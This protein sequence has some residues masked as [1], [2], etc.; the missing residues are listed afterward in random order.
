MKMVN[1]TDDDREWFEKA[2][3]E[4]DAGNVLSDELQEVPSPF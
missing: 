1:I 4:A 2:A 3:A